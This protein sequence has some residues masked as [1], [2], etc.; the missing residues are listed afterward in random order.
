MPE[1]PEATVLH[2]CQGRARLRIS[3]RRRD[4][5]YFSVLENALSQ[6]EG[7][8]T[9]ST[10]PVTASVLVLHQTKPDK[11]YRFAGRNGLFRVTDKPG[12]F[13]PVAGAIKKSGAGIAKATGRMARGEVKAAD[14]SVLVLVG[15]SLYQIARGNIRAPAWYTSLW[16]AYNIGRSSLRN[17]DNS[18]LES[19]AGREK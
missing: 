10:N 13:A 5:G 11:L 4:V 7:V 19:T 1:V 12:T 6:C 3:S 18:A 8:L 16:Y 14:L 17:R 15:L 2:S 9:I